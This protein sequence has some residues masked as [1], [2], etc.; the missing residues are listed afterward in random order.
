MVPVVKEPITGGVAHIN[1]GPSNADV[2][3]RDS[4]SVAAAAI[5]GGSL[6]GSVTLGVSPTER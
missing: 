1:L 6:T 3:P 2:P 5:V 4:Q